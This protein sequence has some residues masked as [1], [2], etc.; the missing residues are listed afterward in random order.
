M[1]K[2]VE[3]F[4]LS[5]KNYVLNQNM[6][7]MFFAPYKWITKYFRTKMIHTVPMPG[8][9]NVQSLGTKTWISFVR[10]FVKINLV[11][12]KFQ[13]FIY[14][15]IY[16]NL[17]LRKWAFGLLVC[18]KFLSQ[19]F[20][21]VFFFT[22]TQDNDSK[23]TPKVHNIWVNG[24]VLILTDEFQ[25]LV[26]QYKNNRKVINGVTRYETICTQ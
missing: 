12:E 7:K 14:L 17:Y 21:V 15:I 6:E 26:S 20:L 23:F 11:C 24:K 19:K 22:N 9:K 8:I 13:R 25:C 1:Q 5:Q 3:S 16:E 2:F 18:E 4:W 10:I